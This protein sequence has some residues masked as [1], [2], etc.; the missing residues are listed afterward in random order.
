MDLIILHVGEIKI[1]IFVNTFVTTWF[2]N[3]C[4]LDCVL[5]IAILQID[6]TSQAKRGERIILFCLNQSKEKG[7]ENNDAIILVR[8][9]S[10]IRDDNHLKTKYA[11]LIREKHV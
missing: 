2:L 8:W 4:L 1:L 9:L 6:D 7:I 5:L 3:E 10:P 11:K